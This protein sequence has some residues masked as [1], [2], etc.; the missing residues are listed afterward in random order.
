MNIVGRDS[1]CFSVETSRR[2]IIRRGANAAARCSG[3]YASEHAYA[4][5][6]IVQQFI[7][8]TALGCRADLAW[9]LLDSDGTDTRTLLVVSL[10]EKPAVVSRVSV[11]ARLEGYALGSRDDMP[12]KIRSKS[13]RE[14]GDRQ[15]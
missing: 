1:A 7:V 6:M 10:D 5:R 9:R 15:S 11:W 4:Y 13:K 2:V 12:A 8:P 3:R 14:R